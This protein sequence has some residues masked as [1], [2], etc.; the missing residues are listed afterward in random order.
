MLQ[1]VPQQNSQQGWDLQIYTL[2]GVRVQFCM[3]SKKRLVYLTQAGTEHGSGMELWSQAQRMAKNAEHALRAA[4]ITI[5]TSREPQPLYRSLR[6]KR[7]MEQHHDSSAT[8]EVCRLQ[9]SQ[10]AAPNNRTQSWALGPG[11]CNQGAAAQPR[12]GS[13]EPQLHKL[14]PKYRAR[15]RAG[16][17]H[18]AF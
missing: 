15:H 3:T 13:P 2:R 17:W 8:A 9:A 18:S 4:S 7:P 12:T 10:S 5:S 11:L 6:Y 1:L 14:S 16:S